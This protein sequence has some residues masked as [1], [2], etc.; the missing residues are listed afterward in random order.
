[1]IKKEDILEQL[2]TEGKMDFGKVESFVKE[3]PIIDEVTKEEMGEFS[4]K[5]SRVPYESFPDRLPTF[6]KMPLPP[7]EHIHIGLYESKQ[8]LYLL[9]ASAYNKAMERI[10]QLETEVENLRKGK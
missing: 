10:E 9:I 3:N 8:T 2:K 4:V 5:L 6:N 1:M 7:D